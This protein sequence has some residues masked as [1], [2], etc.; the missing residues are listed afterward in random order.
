MLDPSVKK[1][2]PSVAEQTDA[3]DENPVNQ[4][5]QNDFRA[6]QKRAEETDGVEEMES[7]QQH[8]MH[9]NSE[10]KKLKSEDDI[11][12]MLNRMELLEREAENE[13][14]IGILLKRN[15]PL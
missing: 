2:T 3:F 8:P 10:T 9:S 7:P 11:E 5:N 6:I 4:D 14:I 15:H 1:R 13:A 12:A